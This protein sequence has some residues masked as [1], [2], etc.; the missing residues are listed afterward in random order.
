MNQIET[1]FTIGM[2]IVA[3]VLIVAI[4]LIDIFGASHEVGALF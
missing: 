4:L 2:S 3:I 1:P